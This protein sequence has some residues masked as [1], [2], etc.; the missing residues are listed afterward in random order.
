MKPFLRMT[1]AVVVALS[2]WISAASAEEIVSRDGRT[3]DVVIESTEPDGIRVR[4]EGSASG[5]IDVPVR[6]IDPYSYYDLRSRHMEETAKNHLLL[7][8]FCAE[9]GLFA[10]ARSQ[11]ERARALDAA[12]VERKFAMTGLV[13]GVAGSIAESARALFAKGD[14]DEAARYAATVMTE[15]AETPAAE[16]AAGLIAEIEASKA[17]REAE[18]LAAA[19]EALAKKEA[20]VREA[21]ENEV[22]PLIRKYE[23]ARKLHNE[24]LAEKSA[25]RSVEMF[26]ASAK[27]FEAVLKS[28]RALAKKHANDETLSKEIDRAIGRITSDAVG[29]WVHAGGVELSRGSLKKAGDCAKKALAIAPESPVAQAFRTRVELATASSDKWWR[30]RRR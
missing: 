20:G 15:F 27:R 14:L 7:A 29:A 1:V 9:N 28:A 13:E 6:S 8:R 22:R 16:D 10:R 11:V 18:E 26:E 5:T 19:S 4:V 23:S 21:L 30:T 25:S 2:G 12:Y 3:F 24:A 17:T